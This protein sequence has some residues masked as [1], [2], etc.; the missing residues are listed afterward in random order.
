MF[1]LN[2]GT[3][4]PFG[5]CPPLRPPFCQRHP[6]GGLETTARCVL[7]AVSEAMWSGGHV[8]LGS[9]CAGRLRDIRASTAGDPGGCGHGPLPK[10]GAS[11]GG[12]S[13]QRLRPVQFLEHVSAA[14]RVALRL[15]R[16]GF[17]GGQPRPQ[18]RT[19]P[20]VPGARPDATAHGSARAAHAAR[21]PCCVPAARTLGSL[22]KRPSQTLPCVPSLP[23]TRRGRPARCA[24]AESC[25]AARGQGG[26]VCPPPAPCGHGPAWSSWTAHTTPEAQR[27]RAGRTGWRD[28]RRSLRTDPAWRTRHP[29]VAPADPSDPFCTGCARGRRGACACVL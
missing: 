18:P 4:A 8:V 1:R 28:R 10:T 26:P 27:G 14:E 21:S 15:A 7:S 11:P 16:R 17:S 23:T 25:P 20:G 29:G 22:H 24:R 19:V 3:G 6:P 13:G 9:L 12:R 2:C 5:A